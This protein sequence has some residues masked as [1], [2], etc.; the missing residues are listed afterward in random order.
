[1]SFTCGPIQCVHVH[2]YVVDSSVNAAFASWSLW[3]SKRRHAERPPPANTTWEMGK[4]LAYLQFYMSL[5]IFW[6][7]YVISF[8]FNKDALVNSSGFISSLGSFHLRTICGRKKMNNALFN[9]DW[10][11]FKPALTELF[12][13]ASAV[14]E[15]R[16]ISQMQLTIKTSWKHPHNGVSVC[17]AFW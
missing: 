4:G 14:L 8:H 2:D 11:T 1:M 6:V 5:I 3:K 9:R 10:A 7:L 12:F 16:L 13:T 17:A 15:Q